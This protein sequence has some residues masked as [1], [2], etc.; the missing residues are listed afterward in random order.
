MII[1][2]EC[3]S[4]QDNVNFFNE[5]DKSRLRPDEQALVKEMSNIRSELKAYTHM[6][7]LINKV[8]NG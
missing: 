6:D 4:I 5:A 8:Q 7:T 1:F 2:L 3:A